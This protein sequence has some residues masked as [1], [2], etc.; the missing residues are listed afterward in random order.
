MSLMPSVC[1]AACMSA[2]VLSC[3]SV[4][5]HP[6]SLLGLASIVVELYITRKYSTLSVSVCEQQAERQISCSTPCA[7]LAAAAV[8]DFFLSFSTVTLILCLAPF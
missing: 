8:E 4:V 1:V 6:F 5:M 3:M 7:S 2:S